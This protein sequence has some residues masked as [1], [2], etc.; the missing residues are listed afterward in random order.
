MTVR[1][2]RAPSDALLALLEDG[3]L[4]EPLRNRWSVA[5]IPLDLQFREGDEVHLYCGLTRL[6]A[7]RRQQSGVRL[8]AA[9]T[10]TSQTCASALFRS[11]RVDESGFGEALDGYLTGVVVDQRWVHKEGLVQ[12]AWMDVREPWATLDREAVLG[13]ASTAARASA[14]DAPAVRGAYEAVDALAAAGGWHRPAA[15]KGANELDQLAVDR[16]GRLVLVELKDARASEVVTAPLQALRY[17]WEWHE[18]LP[19][20]LPSLRAL[21]TSRRRLHLVPEGTP[22]LSGELRAIVGWADGS[23][24]VEVHRRM[25]AVKQ[26]VDAHLPPGIVEVEVWALRA[27][28]AS[29][30][31]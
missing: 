12:A 3:G 18:A 25:L 16:Q 10:Y 21:L 30:V 13:R 7:A 26:V 14:L 6:V 22:E 27:G 31:A 4:L 23:P 2:D 29:R 19:S 8:R 5:G 28:T 9:A 17:A 20:V 15:P 11:W 24:S 1:Y